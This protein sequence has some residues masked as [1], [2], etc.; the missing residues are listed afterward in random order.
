MGVFAG[1]NIVEDGIMLYLDAAD[2]KSYPGSGTTWFD[3]SGN[4]R[5]ATLKNSSAGLPTHSTN[6]NGYF[7]FVNNGSYATVGHDSEIASA[8]FDDSWNFT[9]GGWVNIHAFYNYG[10]LINKA[11]SGWY[12]GS[13]NG[14]W[15]D[16]AGGG[17]VLALSCTSESSN[18]SGY[19]HSHQLYPGAGSGAVDLIVT[20]SWLK[21]DYVGLGTNN[22]KVYLNGIDTN[23][24]AQIG[25]VSRTRNTNT[26]HISI[27][28]RSAPSGTATSTPAVD[29]FISSVYVYGRGLSADEIK[30]NYE[31]TKGRFG[32]L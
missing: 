2:P 8:A 19:L 5:H 13:T 30:Q 10:T 27:G 28:T 32:T 24:V 16:A 20:D 17:R 14:I 4:G 15:L 21:I 3:L 11:A 31:A 23:Q 29:G 7:D 6:N 1:P 22:T 25:S 9:L 18:P 26:S 12:S